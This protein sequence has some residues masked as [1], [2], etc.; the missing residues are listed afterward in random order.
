MRQADCAEWRRTCL[1]DD[2]ERI[3]PLPYKFGK[4]R[5]KIAFGAGVED[6]N[7]PSDCMTR[8]FNICSMGF[9]VRV[10]RVQHYGR[11]RSG[12]HQLAQ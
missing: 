1:P 10:L 5:F 8:L 4:C 11:R 9:R 6:L 2:N 7:L 12:R 3:C